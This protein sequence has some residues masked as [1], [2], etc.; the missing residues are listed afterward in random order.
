MRTSPKLISTA[1]LAAT[2]I[3]CGAQDQ[4]A[5]NTDSQATV[6]KSPS[7]SVETGTQT[8]SFDINVRSAL[9]AGISAS[10]A[11]VTI[12]KG[13]MVRTQEINLEGDSASVSFASLPI[14]EYQVAIQVFDG[15][16]VVAEG[17]GTANVNADTQSEIDLVLNAVTGN[18]QVNLCMPD[19]SVEYQSGSV[20]AVYTALP[21]DET[22]FRKDVMTESAAIE[23]NQKLTS[24]SEMEI[25]LRVGSGEITPKQEFLVPPQIPG[26]AE[27]DKPVKNIDHGA[28]L[29]IVMNDETKLSI[30][31]CGTAMYALAQP[32]GIEFVFVIDTDFS[33]NLIND[34]LGTIKSTQLTV[35]VDLSKEGYELADGL[36][37]FKEVDLTQFDQAKVYIGVPMPDSGTG[38]AA[39]S[40][41]FENMKLLS[42]YVGDTEQQSPTWE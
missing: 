19:S 34:G 14:G 22:G 40:A 4:G 41:G 39:L 1:V 29:S 37:D 31:G 21:D 26:G 27:P 17:S 18:L 6:D 25:K 42:V 20:S 13:E 33:A 15:T 7:A 36:T 5:E 38:L 11:T 24:G 8:L 10:N 35:S 23:L 16:T 3:A 32:D 28:S 9:A 2:L 12:T 30:S